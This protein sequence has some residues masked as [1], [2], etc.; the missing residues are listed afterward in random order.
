[1]EYSKLVAVSGLPGLYELINSKTDGAIVRSLDD[2]S[3]RFISSRIHQFSH[4]ESIEVFTKEDN[5]NLIE[6]FEAMKKNGGSLPDE[7][8]P[9]SIKKYFETV[10]PA[11][12][13]ERVYGSDQK[14]MVR[15]FDVLNKHNIELKLTEPVP[16]PELEPIPV[17]EEKT[18]KKEKP[19]PAPEKKK[20]KAA[21]VPEKKKETKE[22]TASTAKKSAPA[23]KVSGTKKSAPASKG[24]AS[25]EKPASKSAGKG[26]KK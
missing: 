3:T 20:E 6:V 10:Y 14:K 22:P 13:F 4:L 12:D 26:K 18:A 19:K 16:E 11:M 21:A 25:K 1:M 7:K 15:W 17:R 2:Q 8:D 24:S 23:A 9:A 5:V